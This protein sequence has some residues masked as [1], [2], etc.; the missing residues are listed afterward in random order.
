MVIMKKII[1]FFVAVLVSGVAFSQSKPSLKV[2]DTQNATAPKIMGAMQKL[3]TDTSFTQR[4][5]DNCTW[6][7]FLNVT[8]NTDTLGIFITQ[9]VDGLNY[10]GYP[11]LDTVYTVGATANLSFDDVCFTG[12]YLRANVLVTDTVSGTLKILTKPLK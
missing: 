7:I 10:V 8:K 2:Q 11:G 6:Q 4:V 9:S 5:I 12:Q 3:T 1:L